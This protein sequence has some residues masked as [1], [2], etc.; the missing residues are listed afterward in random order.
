M[1]LA[2]IET[3]LNDPTLKNKIKAALIM[4]AVAVKYED[5]QTANHAARIDLASK[6]MSDPNGWADKVNRYVVGAIQANDT[7]I[8]VAELQASSD[9]TIQ[10]HVNASYD[11][12]IEV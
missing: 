3:Q 8:T 10:S 4:S 9:A 11:I 1:T 2:E 5:P 6:F 12:F 7:D